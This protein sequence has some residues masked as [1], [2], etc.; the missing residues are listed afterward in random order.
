MKKHERELTD[1]W[2]NTLFASGGTRDSLEPRTSIAK[3]STRLDRRIDLLLS[4]A[5][6]SGISLP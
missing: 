3:I 6:S 1:E 5:F 2:E 4:F